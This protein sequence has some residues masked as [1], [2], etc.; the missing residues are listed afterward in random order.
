[1]KRIILLFTTL[2]ILCI[3]QITYIPDVNFEQALINF[4]YDTG[5]PDGSVPTA[6]ISS[7]TCLSN[8]WWTGCNTSLNGLNISDLTGIEDFTALT[9]LSIDANQITSLDLSQNINLRHLYCHGNQLTSLDLSNN[10]QLKSLYCAGNLL[11]SLDLT[12]N[13]NLDNLHCSF[14]QLTSLDL[15]PNTGCYDTLWCDNNLLSSLDL[16]QNICFTNLNC[17]NNQLNCLNVQ[18]GS[19][20]T[21]SLF[22]GAFLIANSNPN[23]SCIQV[24]DSA[25][26]ALYWSTYIDPQTSFSVNCNY[27]LSC[28]N[29]ASATEI[30]N[31]LSIFPNPTNNLLKI[32]IENYNGAI[33]SKLYDFSGRLLKVTDN[34]IINLVNY[35][36]GIY[37]LKVSYDDRVEQLK[38]IKD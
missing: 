37:F 34:T 24:D 1:M 32:E 21:L 35:P 2:P 17:S 8:I 33:N 16:S 5:S 23:L 11:T 12:Q 6:N 29:S 36:K 18:N 28:F 7:I 4:G 22:G 3:S 20:D 30:T 38:V 31:S 14:N 25:W 13:T 27:P 26:S 10:S 15:S 9:I 19:N